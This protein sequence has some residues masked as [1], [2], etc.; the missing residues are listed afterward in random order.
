MGI[1]GNQLIN[2]LG[3]CTSEQRSHFRALSMKSI[4]SYEEQYGEQNIKT[5]PYKGK[6]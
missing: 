4:E 2:V 5:V 1:K 6:N 3:E